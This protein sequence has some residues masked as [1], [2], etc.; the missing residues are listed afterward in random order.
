MRSKS[1]LVLLIVVLAAPIALAQNLTVKQPVSDWAG[2]IDQSTH[3]RLNSYLW[4]L[5]QKTGAELAVQSSF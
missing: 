1:L 4:E 3:G 5:K 2:V